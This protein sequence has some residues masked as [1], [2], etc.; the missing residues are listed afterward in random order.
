MPPSVLIVDSSAENREVLRTVLQ[1]RGL[2]IFEADA[3]EAGLELT[4]AHHPDVIVLDA[5]GAAEE[6]D[7][8]QGRFAAES[9]GHDSQ[10]IVLGK[11]RRPPTFAGGHVIAKPYHYAPLIRTIERLASKA[12]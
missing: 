5:E 6:R 12:A 4:R 2:T 3:A 1:R 10:L 11:I 9:A 8:I 7:E